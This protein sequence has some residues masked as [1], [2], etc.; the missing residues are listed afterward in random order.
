MLGTHAPVSLDHPLEQEV[1]GRFEGITM[2]GPYFYFI[3]LVD[4]CRQIHPSHTAKL[5]GKRG[6]GNTNIAHLPCKCNAHLPEES[7][8]ALTA[9]IMWIL[10]GS[11]KEI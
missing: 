3:L 1:L 2:P 4:G 7:H 5:P 9:E 8:N 6:Q 11:E 10:R